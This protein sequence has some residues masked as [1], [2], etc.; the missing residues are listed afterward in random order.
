[1][2]LFTYTHRVAYA[3]CTIGDHIYYSRYL[4]LLEAARGECFRY[5]GVTLK[6]WQ[7]RAVTFPVTDCRV[8]YRLPARYD[9]LISIEVR[10]TV[11]HGARLAFAY[12]V[13]NE[14]GG[15]ILEAETVHAC[16]G[17]EGKPKRL[18]PE[19]CAQLAPFIPH[20]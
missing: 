7:Q 5:L 1:M 4:D 18:P 6:Q 16:A 14:A 15:L 11:A 8:H 12:R 10:V 19:L 17:L 20:P 13:L 9:D 3:D 2:P